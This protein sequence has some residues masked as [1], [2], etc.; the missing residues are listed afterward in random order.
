MNH[1]IFAKCVFKNFYSKTCN[2]LLDKRMRMENARDPALIRGSE[3][4]PEK[5]MATQFS[6]LA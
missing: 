3:R 5:R 2:Y 4:S 6:V 1:I